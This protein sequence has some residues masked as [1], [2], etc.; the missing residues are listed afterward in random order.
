MYVENYVVIYYV[1]ADQ[2]AKTQAVT[3]QFTPY[4]IYTSAFN[5]CSDEK[6]KGALFV[7][8]CGKKQLK[9]HERKTQQQV[10]DDLNRFTCVDYNLQAQQQLRGTH[11]HTYIRM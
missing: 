8:V 5:T 9:N 3:A 11:I 2:G 4:R 7:G 10:V 1:P 6:K